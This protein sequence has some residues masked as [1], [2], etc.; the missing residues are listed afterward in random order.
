MVLSQFCVAMQQDVALADGGE[1][2]A[3]E[4]AGGEEGEQV[5]NI[6]Y[7]Q[8]PSLPNPLL[9]GGTKDQ[10]VASLTLE[11]LASITPNGGAVFFGIVVVMTMLATRNFDP[12]LIFDALEQDE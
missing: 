4:D 1:E 8:A 12:R 11:P 2:A 7:W 6:L 3:A 5:L 10:D 9:S